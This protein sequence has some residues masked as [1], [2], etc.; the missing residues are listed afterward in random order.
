MKCSVK[1]FHVFLRGSCLF[2]LWKLWQ[3]LLAS[4]ATDYEGKNYNI[5]YADQKKANNLYD[6]HSMFL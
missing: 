6:R 2:G 3:T 4:Y 5:K 1:L